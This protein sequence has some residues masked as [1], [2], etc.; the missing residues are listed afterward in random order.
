MQEGGGQFLDIKIGGGGC[1]LIGVLRRERVLEVVL[2]VRSAGLA[3]V[4]GGC[5]FVVVLH[6][7]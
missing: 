2:E 4:A 6:V 1:N 5:E 3:V 7:V